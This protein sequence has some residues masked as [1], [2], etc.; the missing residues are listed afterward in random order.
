MMIRMVAIGEADDEGFVRLFF[1][2]NG[3][4]RVARVTDRQKSANSSKPPK[5]EDG[6]PLHLAAPM[7][8]MVATLA[9]KQGQKVKP[10]DLLMTIEAMKMETALNADRSGTIARVLVGAGSQIDAKDLLLEFQ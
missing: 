9:V 10:G 1:E 8:G 7:P 2:V 4:P 3:Q 5:A 6:N